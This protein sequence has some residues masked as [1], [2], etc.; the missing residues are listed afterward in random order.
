MLWNSV[1][2]YDWLLFILAGGGA[3][4][5]KSLSF[6]FLNPAVISVICAG[7]LAVYISCV[8]LSLRLLT[9]EIVLLRLI[10]I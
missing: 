6:L 5:V 7:S 8:G 2:D 3:D 10:Y 9:I 1:V 4:S